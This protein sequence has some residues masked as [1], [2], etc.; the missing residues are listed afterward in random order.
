MAA[1]TED[2]IREA[3]ILFA[4]YPCFDN[5]IQPPK[6]VI[7]MSPKDAIV[8]SPKVTTSKKRKIQSPTSSPNRS[9][10]GIARDIFIPAKERIETLLLVQKILNSIRPTQGKKFRKSYD[11]TPIN[12]DIFVSELKVFS[13][14]LSTVHCA[15]CEQSI[16]HDAVRCKHQIAH[17]DNPFEEEECGTHIYC[18]KCFVVIEKARVPGEIAVCIG[19]LRKKKGGCKKSKSIGLE[20][21]KKRRKNTEK[22]RKTT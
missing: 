10:V 4:M 8:M 5:D 14:Q 16:P 15:V 17:I 22:H 21:P 19:T 12:E 3:E 7:V 11:L 2:F 9:K 20:P 1:A 13:Y 18:L 6:D